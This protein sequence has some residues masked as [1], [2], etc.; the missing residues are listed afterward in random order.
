[1]VV[2]L[3]STR[4]TL[5]MIAGAGTS[6]PSDRRRPASALVEGDLDVLITVATVTFGEVLD[7]ALELLPE[8]FGAARRR[9][10]RA[11]ERLIVPILRRRSRDAAASVGTSLLWSRNHVPAAPPGPSAPPGRSRPPAAAART[12]DHVRAREALLGDVCQPRA[13]PGRPRL[14]GRAGVSCSDIK[15]AP[16]RSRPYRGSLA[17]GSWAAARVFTHRDLH[18]V[19]PSK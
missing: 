6:V 9:V 8:R 12:G 1:M 5:V 16:D 15:G 7:A 2:T 14:A 11:R 13:A 19:S 3:P 17:S 10:R 4:L 18:H